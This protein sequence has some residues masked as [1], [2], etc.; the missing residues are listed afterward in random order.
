M[1]RVRI[2]SPKN[3]VTVTVTVHHNSL[4]PFRSVIVLDG[5]EAPWFPR[6]IS[7]LDRVANKV[8]EAGKDIEADH[9]GFLDEGK[10]IFDFLV[11]P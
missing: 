4:T 1:I 9:P 8:L 6:H 2:N 7:E 3:T 5:R 11:S 10:S